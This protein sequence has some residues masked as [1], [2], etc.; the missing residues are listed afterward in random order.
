[1]KKLLIALAAFAYAALAPAQSARGQVREIANYQINDIAIATADPYGY[2]IYYN[3]AVVQQV[4]PLVATFARAHEYG[5][6]YLGH[7]ARHM[8]AQDPYTRLMLDQQA[9]IEADLY[10]ARQLA[11]QPAVIQA[12]VAF[13]THSG[14]PGDHT[15]LPGPQR[16]L[17]IRQ[18][19]AQA[20]NGDDAYPQNTGLVRATDY[21]PHDDTRGPSN[22]YLLEEAASVVEALADEDFEGVTDFFNDQLAQQLPAGRIEQVWQGVIAQLGD[23]VEQG[24]P[25]LTREQGYNTVTIR[26]DLVHGA[27][28][29]KVVFDQQDQV[30]GLW[31][32]PAQAAY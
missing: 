17:L 15:H 21:A 7:V 23:F 13:F 27:V 16:A 22:G 4:G 19:V 9:E 6:I 24:S 12:T 10:A 2:V 18:A 28:V 20:G 32:H 25:R 5:H 26:C 31:V 29:V 3:P 1:M 11:D 8:Q 30:A 14:N